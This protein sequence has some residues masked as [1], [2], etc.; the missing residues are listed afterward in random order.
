MKFY[1]FF[2]E[3]RSQEERI[4]GRREGIE[5]LFTC[6]HL[7]KPWTKKYL[8]TAETAGDDSKSP[9]FHFNE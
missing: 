1:F 4:I 8:L 9:F 2:V 3:V 6:R 5:L 7:E